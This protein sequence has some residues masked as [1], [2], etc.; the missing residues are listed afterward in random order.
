MTDSGLK[1][2]GV[3]ALSAAHPREYYS[4]KRFT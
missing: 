3:L 1:H 4:A 2:E